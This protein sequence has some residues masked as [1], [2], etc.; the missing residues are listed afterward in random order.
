MAQLAPWKQRPH[1][2]WVWAFVAGFF[3]C[4]CG[5][6]S[7]PHHP[8]T[9]HGGTYHCLLP[10]CREQAENPMVGHGFKYWLT[11]QGMDHISHQTGKFGK[12]STQICHSSGGYVKFPW[13]VSSSEKK[14]VTYLFSHSS[15]VQW[16]MTLKWK[17]TNSGDT[18]FFS[19]EQAWL[20]E[21]G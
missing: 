1:R 11:L 16:K 8:R 13:R 7:S 15:R 6:W 18:P 4:S 9:T 2:L 12:S 14:R 10:A 17:E 3:H 5:S 19:T 20:W 21:T